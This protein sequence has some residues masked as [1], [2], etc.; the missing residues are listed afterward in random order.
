MKNFLALAL[1][2]L[3]VDL[4]GQFT[5]FDQDAIDSIEQIIGFEMAIQ[6][7]VGLSVGILKD[8]E[9]AHLQGYGV[10]NLDTNE[11]ATAN[12]LY[13]LASISK[14]I[15]AVLSLQA[16]EQGHLDLTC[17]IRKYVPEYP[18]KPQGII[19]SGDLLSNE[20]GIIHYN[21][22]QYCSANFDELARNNYSTNHTNIYSPIAAIEIFK[23]QPICF[24]PGEHFQY[25]TWGFCLMA[26]VL[27]RAVGRSYQEVLFENIVCA[28]DLPSLQI[29]FQDRRPYQNEVAGYEVVAGIV[30]P[31]SPHFDLSDVSYKVGGGGLVGSAVDLT[32]FIKG[33]VNDELLTISSKDLMGAINIPADGS[34]SNYGYGTFSGF[35]NGGRLYWH[36]GTQSKTATLIYFSP[37]SRNGVVLL[38]NTQNVNLFG[39]ASSIFDFLPGIALHSD[40]DFTPQSECWVHTSPAPG[41]Y[42][43]AFKIS[44][45]GP[46]IDS[47]RLK[48][49]N[50]ILLEPGFEAP[51]GSEFHAITCPD[52]N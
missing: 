30:Q 44:V 27:E 21:S 12:S 4:F 35:R 51:M 52:C 10:V 20:S 40:S 47:L 1:A 5:R 11:P 2:F 24:A 43:S 14:T 32:L 31:P 23:D 26:A 49:K 28:L 34:P 48:A 46:V 33:I 17:D 38:C 22:S 6:Q 29:E 25:T 42:Q 50:E 19:T 45:V 39:L 8:G 36:F 18:S 13:R 9:I 15:T 16:V 7:M 37:D 3:L 41:L